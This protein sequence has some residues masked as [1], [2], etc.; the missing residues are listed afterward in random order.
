MKII[1]DW[2][3]NRLRQ[4]AA[5]AVQEISPSLLEIKSQLASQNL[6]G[7]SQW[8]ESSLWEPPVQIAIRDLCKPGKIVFDVGAN[9]GGLTTVMSRMVGPKGVVCAFEA[10]PRIVDKC[11]RNIILSGCN[12]V[13][14]YNLAVYH[15][16]H[17]KVP[18]YLGGHLNDSIYTNNNTEVAAFNVSTIAIDDFVE[19]TGLVPDLIKMDIEGAEFDAVQGM[20]RTI[21]NAKPHMILETQPNDTRCLDLLRK[22]GYIAI[23]LNTYREVLS[24]ADYPPGVG[25]R[26]NLY[27]HRDRLSEV[28]YRPP[29]NLIE[30]ST[31]TSNEFKV[32][33]NGS[34]DLKSPLVLGKGRYLID[35]DFSAD[36]TN[37]EMMCG[38]KLGETVIFRYHAYT[39]LIADSY[40]DWVIDLTETSEVNLYF[41]F[42]NNTHDE[43]FFIKGVKISRLAEFDS[44]T[45]PFYI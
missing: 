6:F 15:K 38:V 9:F 21:S 33:N 26:N 7:I 29:F 34:I 37:N 2:I 10:S 44:L 4:A 11:Q 31:L 36:G 43:T 1:K 14:V 19:F 42:L 16:S 32:S 17:Q 22:D 35:C 41:D 45:P 5:I 30:A 39:K 27:I 20:L 40:R 13:Q 28:L 8:Y 12:N 3:K 24:P 23:D 18:I 25:I